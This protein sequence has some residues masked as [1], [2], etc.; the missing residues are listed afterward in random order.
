MKPGRRALIPT[1]AGFFRWDAI[2]RGPTTWSLIV[3]AFR[4]D[5]LQNQICAAPRL[6]V[7]VI[8]INRVAVL[9]K[10]TG[11]GSFK[12]LRSIVPPVRVRPLHSLEV[13]APDARRT[14]FLDMP[15]TNGQTI[16]PCTMTTGDIARLAFI[17]A[18]S[19]TR[20]TLLR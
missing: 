17:A 3:L 7:A 14:D 9:S 5:P 1:A 16:A 15:C 19:G 11:R 12:K 20:F 13:C 18:A 10:M 6:M 8:P 2:T 4:F